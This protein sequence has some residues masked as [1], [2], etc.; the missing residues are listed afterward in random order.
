MASRR[1]R[2]PTSWPSVVT[3][4]PTIPSALSFVAELEAKAVQAAERPA[5]FPARDDIGP[6]LRVAFHGR[7][8]LFFR[9]LA[10]E[11]RIV[12][13]LHGARDLR[14]ILGA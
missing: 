10:D 14:R 9:D 7:Y 8:L 5:S 3:S 13:I 4:P 12:R 1:P 2:G 6:G 11:V